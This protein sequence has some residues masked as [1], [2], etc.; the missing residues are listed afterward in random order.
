MI[1]TMTKQCITIPKF[2]SPLFRGLIAFNIVFAIYLIFASNT[3]NTKS[4][5]FNINSKISKLNDKIFD[6]NSNNEDMIW[7]STET[8][9]SYSVIKNYIPSDEKPDY[10]KSVTLTTQGTYE[11]LYHIEILCKRWDGHLSVG[12]YAPG[13]DFNLAVNLIY[14]LRE[15]KHSCV[16]TKTSWHLVYDTTFGPQSI[17]FPVSYVNDMNFD[18]SQSFK[19]IADKFNVRFRSDRALPYPINVCRN[20]ARLSAGTNYVFASDI[21]LYPSVGIVSAFLELLDREKRGL[22]R[23]ISKS[24]RHVYVLPVFEVEAEVEPPL[25]KS[26]LRALFKKGNCFD[27]EL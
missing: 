6:S 9:G 1:S 25:N 22:V 8:R 16:K 2:K 21:E 18:C 5:S 20:V 15:C 23:M 14:Y 27:Q 13:D 10:N 17:L 4:S 3:I 26:E 11:F 12:V 19:E 7:W 24:V